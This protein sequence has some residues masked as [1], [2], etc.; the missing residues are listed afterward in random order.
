ML[1]KGQAFVKVT[2]KTSLKTYVDNH[3]YKNKKGNVPKTYHGLYIHVCTTRLCGHLWES[4]NVFPRGPRNM[5]GI[6][7][8]LVYLPKGET[9]IYF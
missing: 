3:A 7:L 8:Y 5:F 4:Q 9:Y 6:R 2:Y 1:I